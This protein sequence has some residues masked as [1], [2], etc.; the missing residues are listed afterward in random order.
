MQNGVVFVLFPIT[1]SP[2]PPPDVHARAI[3]IFGK[4][5]LN[6]LTVDSLHV[7]F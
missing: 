2:P 3:C 4:L 7:F 1:Q 6:L 5:G